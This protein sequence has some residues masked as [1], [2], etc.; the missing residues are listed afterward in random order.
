[1]VETK[2]QKQT[3]RL[4]LCVLF[5]SGLGEKWREKQS[6]ET[7]GKSR[8]VYRPSFWEVVLTIG[9]GRPWFWEGKV[10]GRC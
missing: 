10:F 4:S 2:S 1:M 8:E 3:R 6:T 9:G 7:T 5:W